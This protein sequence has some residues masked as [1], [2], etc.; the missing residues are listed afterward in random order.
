MVSGTTWGPNKETLKATY[1]GY[2]GPVLEYAAQAW[3]TC[4]APSNVVKLQ[5]IQSAAERIMTGCH[6]GTRLQHLSDETRILPVQRK[7]DMLSCQWAARSQDPLH[8]NH[9]VLDRAPGTGTVDSLASRHR[10]TLEKIGRKN[11]NA[12]PRDV[13]ELVHTKFV[14]DF[15][16][17]APG[18]PILGGAAPKVSETERTLPRH[19]RA[20]LA[21]LRSGVCSLL[22]E[23]QKTWKM[24]LSDLCRSCKTV[25]EDTQH[26]FACRKRPTTLT[27][28][29]L[30]RHPT[31]VAEYLNLQMV[32]SL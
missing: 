27:V 12:V 7:I 5:R 2:I 24:S 16:A 30:W 6:A 18:N 26:L 1:K 14:E 21:Q 9:G 28:I 29:D 4:A 19:T 22:Q 23:T 8:P 31:S 10:H 15:L 32:Q 17:A 3:S 25:K 20:I 13:A 11:P